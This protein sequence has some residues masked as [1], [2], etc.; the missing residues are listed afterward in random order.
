MKTI[1]NGDIAGVDVQVLA[2]HEHHWPAG[3]RLHHEPPNDAD[4]P[5]I[6][7]LW[8]IQQ[9][10]VAFQTEEKRRVKN[11]ELCLLPV[12]LERDVF[13][14]QAASWISLRL[15]ITVFNKFNLLKNIALPAQWLPDDAERFQMESW[16][17]QI[18][19]EFRMEQDY[20]R[21]VVNGLIQALFGFCWPHLTSQSLVWSIQSELPE[22]LAQ[23]MRRI[24]DDPAS[25][26]TSLAREAGFSPA[27]FRRAFHQQIGTSPREY[28][29]SHR[30]EAACHYLRHTD[31]PV[32]TIVERIGLRNVNHFSQIFKDIYGMPPSHYRVSQQKEEI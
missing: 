21:L 9:G 11:G 7:H 3:E 16:M 26:V 23:T 10:Y 29:H 12:G 4:N 19:R 1:Q 5:F 14:P 13:T 18:I 31:L 20:H 6:F 15:S 22:W 24:A 2:V 8:L 30:F 27:Q 28:L 17:M 32:R 25:T